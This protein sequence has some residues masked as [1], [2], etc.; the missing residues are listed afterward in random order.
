MEVLL[1]VVL[2]IEG[3]LH[4]RVDL[5][6]EILRPPFML[7]HDPQLLDVSLYSFPICICVIETDIQLE[8]SSP[9]LRAE[10]LVD[11][12]GY[13]SSL[14]VIRLVVVTQQV[15]NLTA[16]Q[17][18]ISASVRGHAKTLALVLSVTHHLLTEGLQGLVAELRFTTTLLMSH[19]SEVLISFINRS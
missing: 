3:L 4:G 18:G 12:I 8:G 15:A 17:L 19:S 5:W 9:L 11:R 10:I 1:H 13:M 2:V 6:T 14:D 16:Y 7:V